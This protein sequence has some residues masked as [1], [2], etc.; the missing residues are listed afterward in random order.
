MLL[1]ILPGLGTRIGTE[2]ELIVKDR[3]R[4]NIHKSQPA[5]NLNFSVCRV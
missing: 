4:K 2:M 3:E 5:I 1:V